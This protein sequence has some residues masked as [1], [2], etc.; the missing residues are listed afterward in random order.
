[1]A[2]PLAKIFTTPAARLVGGDLYEPKDTDMDGKPLLFKSGPKEG[3]PGRVE[4]YIAIA[5][6]K[7]TAPHW[8]SDEWGGIVWG[9]GHAGKANAGQGQFS[10]KIKDG[11]DATPDDKGRRPCDREGY[12]GHWILHLSSGYPFS[13]FKQKPGSVPAFW[14]P[15][16]QPGAIALG[17]FIQ[18]QI[19]C[20]YNGSTK[21]PGV[22]LN[23]NMVAFLAYGPLI[24]KATADPSS[25]N[26]GNVAL[27]AG[28]SAAPPANFAPPPPATP[29]APPPPGA[30][31]APPAPPLVPG[32]PAA[33]PPP[34]PPPAAAGGL[35]QVPGAAHTIEVC[36]AGG[37]TDDQIV[38]AGIATR[39]AT[40]LPPAGSAPP[41]PPPAPI[42]SAPGVT[43]NAGYMAVPPPPGAAAAPPPPPPPPAAA[44]RHMLPAAQGATYEQ[45]IARG[46]NDAQLV[47]NGMMSA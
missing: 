10:W 47:Q 46:W 45:M 1:M 26:F 5:V 44:A 27:P 29:G 7:S 39:V 16:A 25:A 20:D 35:V 11:D 33:A 4:Y 2:S 9:V 17:S 18:V 14:E 30:P 21:Q 42:A 15:W 12:A 23:P 8:A 31:A 6:A 36:R 13:I 38:G 43:P 24:A 41:P 40:P 37:W 19:T 32:L 3:Q 34:P 22:Y 28:A